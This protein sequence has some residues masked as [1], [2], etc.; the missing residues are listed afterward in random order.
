[1]SIPD[2]QSGQ[3]IDML[4]SSVMIPAIAG[5]ICSNV[6]PA[7]DSI[8]LLDVGTGDGSSAGYLMEVIEG[9]GI[10]ISQAGFLDKGTAAFQ[11]LILNLTSGPH[12]GKDLVVMDSL[13]PLEYYEN[14]YDAANLQMVLHQISN[15]DMRS[16]I[17]AKIYGIK[18]IWCC[19]RYRI[20]PRLFTIFS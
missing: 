18:T 2:I 7:M 6:D 9:N 4:K 14:L 12:K 19:R 17:F 8:A 20:S 10:N 5:L 16:L 13:S 1:M 11:N 15:P 3:S